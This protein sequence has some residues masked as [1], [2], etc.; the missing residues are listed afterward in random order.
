MRQLEAALHLDPLSLDVRRL[1]ANVQISAGL[2]DRALDNCQR[3][4]DVDPVPFVA[5]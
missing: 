3:V 5:A 4:L 2:Y 1:L